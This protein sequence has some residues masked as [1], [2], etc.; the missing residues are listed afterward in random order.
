M[1]LQKFIHTLAERNYNKFDSYTAKQSA[2]QK[3]L[4]RNPD[5]HMPPKLESNCSYLDAHPY[6]RHCV[7]SIDIR[8]LI[9]IVNE[10]GEP[11]TTEHNV[12]EI[13]MNY[14]L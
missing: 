9:K 14:T 2:R 4:I 8:C 12:R 10:V 6:L 11:S 3:V 5:N 1:H 13:L 7:L